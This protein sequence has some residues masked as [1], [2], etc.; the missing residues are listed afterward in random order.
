MDRPKLKEV[1]LEDG[2]VEVIETFYPKV[3]PQAS[4]LRVGSRATHSHSVFSHFNIFN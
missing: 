4:S 1:V 2:C 3:R